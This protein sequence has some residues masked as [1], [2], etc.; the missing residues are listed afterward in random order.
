MREQ[1]QVSFWVCELDGCGH[2][3]PA[4][5][6]T[7]PDKCGKCGRR[8]WHVT[9]TVAELIRE[10]APDIDDRIRRIV[11]EE[12]AS[13]QAVPRSLPAIRHNVPEPQIIPPPARPSLDSL[14]NICAGLTTPQPLEPADRPPCDFTQYDDQTGETYRCGLLAHPAKVKHTRGP[15]V[16]TGPTL[17]IA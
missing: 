17:G 1:R 13:V 14:R 5:S 15:K 6:E 8:R 9:K 7:P 11:R 10:K 3:W 4:K 2:V 16:A 12:M